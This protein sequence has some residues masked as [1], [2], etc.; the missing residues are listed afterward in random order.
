MALATGEAVKTGFL[1]GRWVRFNRA[2]G[3]FSGQSVPD[4]NGQVALLG[5]YEKDGWWNVTIFTDDMPLVEQ[6]E[7]ALA[8]DR[9]SKNLIA[10]EDDL[11]LD[12]R[13]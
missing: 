13:N 7:K 11:T 10:H 9:D 8:G 3:S 2:T 12:G 5:T 4:D 1:T 6:V